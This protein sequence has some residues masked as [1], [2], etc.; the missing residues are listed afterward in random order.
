MPNTLEKQLRAEI[1]KR[2]QEKKRQEKAKSKKKKTFVLI[3]VLGTLSLVVSLAQW[4]MAKSA[5]AQLNR[6]IPEGERQS[7]NAY[8][9]ETI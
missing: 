6:P 9:S 8:R 3:A 5:P 4:Q 7:P 1:L 2:Q